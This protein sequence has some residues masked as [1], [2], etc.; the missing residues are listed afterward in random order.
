MTLSLDAYATAVQPEIAQFSGTHVL[1]FFRGDNLEA[2]VESAEQGTDESRIMIRGF[3][4]IT[5]AATVFGSVLAAERW[6]GTATVTPESP[7]DALGLCP[8]RASTRY[9]RGRIRIPAGTAWSFALGLE[10]DIS[11]EGGR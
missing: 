5:D 4:P 2:T 7:M 9:A 10:P 6:P 1:G 8:Q 3:R 11:L